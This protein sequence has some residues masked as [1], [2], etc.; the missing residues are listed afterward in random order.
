MDFQAKSSKILALKYLSK[1]LQTIVYK[2]C[3]SQ[4]CQLW[5]QNISLKRHTT[6]DRSLLL[7]VR[8]TN[9]SWRSYFWPLPAMEAIQNDHSDAVLKNGN[10]FWGCF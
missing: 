7:R 4:K 1:R 8:F 6:I 2:H 5:P 10:G 9:K 3:L